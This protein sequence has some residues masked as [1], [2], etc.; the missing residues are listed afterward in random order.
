MVRERVGTPGHITSTRQR[1]PHFLGQLLVPPHRQES[2]YSRL[3]EYLQERTTRFAKLQET[4]EPCL[5]QEWLG[6]LP[7]Q[8]YNQGIAWSS[9]RQEQAET[10]ADASQCEPQY[11]VAQSYKANATNFC[12]LLNNRNDC[13]ATKDAGSGEGQGNRRPLLR[14]NKECMPMHVASSS[15]G[16]IGL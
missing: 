1:H 5:S 10:P 4:R 14:Q 13:K 9:R 15:L 6:S 2:E 12:A 16:C 8:Q 7:M 11:G 3:P